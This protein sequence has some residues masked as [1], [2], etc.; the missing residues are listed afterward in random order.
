MKEVLS[1]QNEKSDKFWRV[2]TNGEIMVTNWGKSGTNGRWQLTEF[3]SCEECE[4][5]AAKLIASKRK[6]GYETVPDFDYEGRVYFD[7]EDFGPNPLT[8]HPIFRQYFGDALYYD[9]GDEDAPF[10]SD[11]GSDA[12]AILQEKYSPKMDF[13]SFPQKLITREWEMPYLPPED[14]VDVSQEDSMR[15]TDQIIL[16]TALGQIKMTG[17][18]KGELLKL[19]YASLNRWERLQEQLREEVTIA[20]IRSDLQRFEREQPQ[21]IL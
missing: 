20:V 12:L 4:K 15:M 13:S 17:A 3:D 19:A 14:Q 2:E 18:V 5:E 9:C 16:A 10:G 11:E 7:C 6:K 1:F 21:R 8:S